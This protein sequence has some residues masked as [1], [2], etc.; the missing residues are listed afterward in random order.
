MV[1]GQLHIV[2]GPGRLVPGRHSP[3]NPCGFFE[4]L[5]ALRDLLSRQDIGDLQ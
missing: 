2:F 3:V 5:P 1:F 4:R